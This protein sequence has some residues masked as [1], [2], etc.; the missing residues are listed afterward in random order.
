MFLDSFIYVFN[1]IH[2]SSQFA[3]LRSKCDM[4]LTVWLSCPVHSVV[5]A[6]Q[7]IVAGASLAQSVSITAVFVHNIKTISAFFGD[8]LRHLSKRDFRHGCVILIFSQNILGDNFLG[9]NG[10]IR[11]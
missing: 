6:G 4:C 7:S 3:C 5:V 10:K 8:V 1:S 9:C 11:R 2:Y